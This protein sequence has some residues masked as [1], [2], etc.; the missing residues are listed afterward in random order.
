[1]KGVDPLTEC[2]VGVSGEGTNINKTERG[3]EMSRDSDE[4]GNTLLLTSGD[5]EI[6]EE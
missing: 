3:S 2:L 5:G 1:V 4:D 6:D